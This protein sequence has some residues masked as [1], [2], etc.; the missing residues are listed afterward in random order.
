MNTPTPS[1]PD[2]TA[3]FD[4]LIAVADNLM[5]VETMLAI[6]R[7]RERE[8][9]EAKHSIEQRIL[10]IGSARLTSGTSFIHADRWLVE[11]LSPE[12]GQQFR[13]TKLI[14]SQSIK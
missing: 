14:K 4:E 7:Q 13:V 8:D 12:E 9:R 5:D 3:L 11:V 6:L 2:I 1:E 10:A